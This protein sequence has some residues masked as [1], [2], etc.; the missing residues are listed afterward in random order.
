MPRNYNDLRL[1]MIDA[2]PDRSGIEFNDG[3]RGDELRAYLD[4]LLLSRVPSL[5]QE[6]E[7]NKARNSLERTYQMLGIGADDSRRM[8]TED[9]AAVATF[10]EGELGKQKPTVA[11]EKAYTVGELQEGVRAALRESFIEHGDRY[12]FSEAHPRP[13]RSELLRPMLMTYVTGVDAVSNV[14]ETAKKLIAA[15][16]GVPKTDGGKIGSHEA[17]QIVRD[18]METCHQHLQKTLGRGI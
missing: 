16:E 15:F 7:I 2:L 11:A 3:S 18:A 13:Y 8:A 6:S 9:F 5:N 14:E 4:A 17:N 12:G 1:K 10:V